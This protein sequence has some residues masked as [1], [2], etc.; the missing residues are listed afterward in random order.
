VL[1][2]KTRVAQVKRVPAGAF[3][4]YGCTWRAPVDT[5]IAVLPVGY[6]DGFDRGL[7]NVG[8][9]LIRGRRAPVR[10]RVCMNVTLVDVTHIPEAGVEDEAVLLGRSGSERVSAEDLAGWC[11]TIAYEIVTR[12]AEHLPRVPVPDEPA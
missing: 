7:S 1:S 12:I 10:G 11:G 9:V 5:R 4:G 6:A 3:V 2:W 8:H